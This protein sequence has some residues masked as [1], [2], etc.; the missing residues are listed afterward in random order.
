MAA[1]DLTSPAY[2]PI[3]VRVTVDASTANKST[4]ISLP[5]DHM[6]LT[7]RFRPIGAAGKVS[8]LTS[9]AHDDDIGTAFTTLTADVTSDDVV[10]PPTLERG[11]TGLSVASATTSTVIEVVL[12]RPSHLK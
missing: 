1:V 11:V 8:F 3:V 4:R 9:L 12:S 7:L 10:I 6:G 5:A 2:W